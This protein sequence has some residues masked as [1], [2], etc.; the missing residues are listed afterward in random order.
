MM[1]D[2][3]PPSRSSALPLPQ[4]RSRYRE[5]LPW[6]PWRDTD[7]DTEKVN[8]LALFGQQADAESPIH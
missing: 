6:T 3:P 7:P 5:Q 2:S 4:H 1:G 8:R